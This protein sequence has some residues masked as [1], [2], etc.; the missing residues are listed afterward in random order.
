MKALV[1]SPF[2]AVKMLFDGLMKP[3]RKAL[4][5]AAKRNHPCRSGCSARVL[6]GLGTIV[7]GATTGIRRTGGR[8]SARDHGAGGRTWWMPSAWC[9]RG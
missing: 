9:S 7:K 4:S 1:K 2:K 6:E 3:V 8:G 5:M